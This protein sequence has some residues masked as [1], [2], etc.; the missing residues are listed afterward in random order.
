MKKVDQRLFS[1]LEDFP[2][3]A[4]TMSNCVQYAGCFLQPIPLPAVQNCPVIPENQR[5]RAYQQSCPP[6]QV[7]AR[8]PASKHAPCRIPSIPASLKELL[9][10]RRLQIF[11]YDRLP[12]HG[13][14]QPYNGN[15]PCAR[16]DKN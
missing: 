1:Q 3:F 9:H 12:F 5:V 4:L 11:L 7:P 15:I 13:A 2:C 16:L 8:L 14:N 6:N 10:L